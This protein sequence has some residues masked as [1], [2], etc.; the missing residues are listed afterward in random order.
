MQR[1]GKNRE[2]EKMKANFTIKGMHCESCKS[3]FKDVAKDFKEIKQFDVDSKTGKAEI[4][5]DDSFD[6]KT[7]KKEIESLGKYKVIL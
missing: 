4:E 3:L 1:A 6:L 7:F 5:C 2:V